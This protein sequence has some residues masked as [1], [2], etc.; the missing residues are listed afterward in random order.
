LIEFEKL[1]DIPLG[2]LLGC[3]TTVDQKDRFLEAASDNVLLSVAPALSWAVA[4]AAL[5]C[6][7]WAPGL[8][9]DPC[10]RQKRAG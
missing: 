2:K 6:L 10:C 7:P 1:I 9:P 8:P 4:S 5:S 3:R